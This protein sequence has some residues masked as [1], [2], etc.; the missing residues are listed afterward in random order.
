MANT[1]VQ[2]FV[3]TFLLLLLGVKEEVESLSIESL[4]DSIP[5]ET[6]DWDLHILSLLG[7]VVSVLDRNVGTVEGNLVHSVGLLSNCKTTKAAPEF[8]VKLKLNFFLVVWLPLV[9]R[10]K[11]LL[12]HIFVAVLDQLKITEDFAGE[13]VGL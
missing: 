1:S 11:S 10:V 3:L 8:N 5:P 9:K 13:D 12:D 2:K 6:G 4:S 7:F